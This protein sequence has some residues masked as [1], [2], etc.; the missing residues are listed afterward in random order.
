[1][2]LITL[3]LKQNVDKKA[4]FITVTF[5]LPSNALFIQLLSGV[6]TQ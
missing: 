2:F 6:I 4:I 5:D 3:K 1:M